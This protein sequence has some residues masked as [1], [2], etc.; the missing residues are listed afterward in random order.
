MTKQRCVEKFDRGF[1]LIEIMVAL[2]ISTVIVG[3]TLSVFLATKKTQ[4][5]STALAEIQQSG[6]FALDYLKR[7][8]RMIGYQGCQSSSGD[9]INVIANGFS[10]SDFIE[11]K[12]T[13]YKV[14][15]TWLNG[16]P[17]S[18]KITAFT[19]TDAFSFGRIRDLDNILSDTE[20]STTNINIV[21][22]PASDFV[23]DDLVMISDCDFADLFQ[24]T[25]TPTV[26]T[27]VVNLT[28]VNT[29]A[30]SNL[31]K[32][33]K[34]AD[35]VISSYKN[36]VYFVNDTGRKNP[37]GEAVMALYRAQSPSYPPE[38]LVEGVENMQIMYGEKLAT[39]KIRFVPAERDSPSIEWGNV[40]S[41]K[42]SLLVASHHGVRNTDDE[43]YYQLL[44]VIL[45][46][47][48]KG[49]DTTHSGKKRLKKVFSTTIS[50]RNRTL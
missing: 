18:D 46:K 2:L 29:A 10:K 16:T 28:Y 11:Q 21:K 5:V 48:S 8:I 23:K 47:P 38:E 36:I 1:T 17:F 49:N 41:M 26:L 27:D 15:N 3:G 24:I 45:A 6:S 37:Q 39:G 7:E 32:V 19:G 9:N 31:S 14:S 4:R 42:I 20:A 12:L 50:I 13:G 34:Q 40:I 43:S 30:T 25:S 35:A 33:Y 22:S 44:D